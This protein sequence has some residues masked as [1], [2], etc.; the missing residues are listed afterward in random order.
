[1]VQQEALASSK[2]LLRAISANDALFAGASERMR[3][4]ASIQWGGDHV[5]IVAY[6]RTVYGER[7]VWEMMA[8]GFETDLVV[9]AGLDSASGP[10]WES[11][12]RARVANWQSDDERFLDVSK[13]P[14][15]EWLDSHEWWNLDC[16]CRVGEDDATFEPELVLQ[17]VTFV[18]PALPP[19]RERA[20][21]ERWIRLMD[22][23]LRPRRP[24]IRPFF[25]IAHHYVA[26][27]A[28]ADAITPCI[29]TL[30]EALGGLVHASRVRKPTLRE[31]ISVM[32]AELEVKTVDQPAEEIV[33]VWDK[34]VEN[35]G[36][37]EM[38]LRA[39]LNNPDE[40]HDPIDIYHDLCVNYWEQVMGAQY[41]VDRRVGICRRWDRWVR[42]L[43]VCQDVN[44]LSSSDDD[45]DDDP[46][47]DGGDD[48]SSMDGSS[49]SDADASSIGDSSDN[50]G[51][52]DDES[53][54]DEMHEH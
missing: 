15:F 48:D 11:W 18:A 38:V 53:G 24:E 2:V 30:C 7:S 51:G 45:D 46:S 1:M 9:F 32:D 22:A 34:F 35:I 37:C 42:G 27:V 5:R 8:V 47:F 52:S 29:E 20:R 19:G 40:G 39:L 26:F 44:P 13:P 50:E 21:V 31:C 54:N 4:L 41:E 17:L 33:R 3:D 12:F 6:S 16:T 28:V 49:S 23:Q 43:F 25:A 10:P 36:S 14:D